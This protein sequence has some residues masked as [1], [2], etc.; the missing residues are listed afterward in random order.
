MSISYKKLAIGIVLDLIG[1]IP[2]PV[3][4][5]LLTPLSGYIMTKMYMGKKGKVAGITSFLEE[6]LPI[7]IIPTFTIMR[8]YTHLIRKKS[9]NKLLKIIPCF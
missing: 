4:S 8:V 6:L 2:I 9:L 3:F 1:F 5:I 7:D